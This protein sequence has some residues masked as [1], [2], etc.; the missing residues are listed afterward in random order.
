MAPLFTED[1]MG[2]SKRIEPKVEQK[3]VPKV[4]KVAPKQ[5]AVKSAIVEIDVP[6]E[7]R[8]NG[9]K[10]IG[11]CEVTRDV[12]EVIIETVHKKQWEVRQGLMGHIKSFD[13]ISGR[14]VI[15]EKLNI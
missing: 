15:K 4:E 7:V 1:K 13:K 2:K 14:V 9:K 6:L 8:I 10:Y 12:A 3:E 11:K 5:E